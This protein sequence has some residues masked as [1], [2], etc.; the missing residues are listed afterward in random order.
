MTAYV[1][2]GEFDP[3]MAKHGE[4][5][6]SQRLA[7]LDFRGTMNISPLSHFGIGVKIL[8]TSHS[9]ETGELHG[10]I[11]DRPVI[12]DDCAW[13]T[14]FSI[15]FNCHI[16]HHAIVATGSVVRN[17]TVEPYS[18]VEGNPAKVVAEWDGKKWNYKKRRRGA[19][20]G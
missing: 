10:P 4:H 5:Y 6:Y 1:C 14:S 3:S 20:N 18:I 17:M 13:I 9:I 19:I 15:L 2:Y 7:F 11:L 8:T 12:V 16:K